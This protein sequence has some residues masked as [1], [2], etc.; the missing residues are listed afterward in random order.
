MSL[1]NGTVTKLRD[2]VAAFDL[3]EHRLREEIQNWPSDDIDM[4]PHE[5]EEARARIAGFRAD[6]QKELRELETKPRRRVAV[7]G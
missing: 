3:A 7:H 4:T 6:V 2:A 5:A 1:R